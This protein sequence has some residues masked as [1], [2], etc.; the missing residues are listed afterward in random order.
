MKTRNDFV[1][2]SSS[3]SFIV[4]TDKGEASQMNPN[5]EKSIVVRIPNE[6]GNLKFGWE[7]ITYAT[8]EDKLNWVGINML[9]QYAAERHAEMKAGRKGGKP[10]KY[11]KT[12]GMFNEW[13]D[14]LKKVVKERFGKDIYFDTKYICVFGEDEPYVDL[15]DCYIDHQSNLFEDPNAMKMFKTEEMLYNFLAYDDSYVSTGNDN[16]PDPN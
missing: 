10:K 13:Y 7:F 11:L 16:E 1:S 15:Q 8:F 9:Y 6:F 12:Y 2:N 4:I 14:M 5:T 3:S